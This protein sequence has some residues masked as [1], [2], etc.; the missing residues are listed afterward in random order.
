MVEQW[1]RETKRSL[2]VAVAARVISCAVVLLVLALQVTT[3]KNGLKVASSDMTV[4]S[5]SIG[6]YIDTGSR[7]DAVSGTAHVLQH[8]A[9]KV[10]S[11]IWRTKL[12]TWLCWTQT[13]RVTL[14]DQSLSL[15]HA[16]VGQLL[17]S[18][19]RPCLRA[20]WRSGLSRRRPRVDGLPGKCD[21]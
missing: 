20:L 3:L 17:S 13:H 8:M 5:T 2:P 18:A 4:P 11:T 14:L 1:R 12:R 15:P 7:Y 10:R 16:V 19:S 6:L 9:F 21:P